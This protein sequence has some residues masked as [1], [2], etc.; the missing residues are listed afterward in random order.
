MGSQRSDASRR[1]RVRLRHSFVHR[2][3]EPS[4]RVAVALVLIV[5]S[6]LVLRLVYPLGIVWVDS[7]TYADAASSMSRWEPV[8][9]PHI[10]GD[11][12]YTQ[13]VRLSLIAPAALLY[14]VFGE[15]DSVSSLFP[16]LMSLAVVP[17]AF[18][19]TRRYFNTVAGLAA[20]GLVAIFP[21]SAII[22]TL[23]MPDGL[24]ASFLAI[25]TVCLLVALYEDRMS[26]RQLVALWFG[27]GAAFAFAF[28]AR[29]TAVCVLPGFALVGLLRWRRLRRETLAALA[30]GVGV[31][32]LFQLLL[33]GLGSQPLEDFRVLFEIGSRTR[34]QVGG[35]GFARFLLDDGKFWPFT[36]TTGVGLLTFALSVRPRAILRSPLTALA[37]IAL[38]EYIYFEFFMDLPGTATFR[39][40]QRYILPLAF[41]M[42]VFGGIGV[43][44]LIDW[45][46]KRSLRGAALVATAIAAALLFT[47]VR[48]LRDEYGYWV[49]ENHRVDAVQRQIVTFLATQ[50]AEPVY[51]SNDDFARPLS[52]R[53]GSAGTYYERTVSKHGLLRNRFDENGA[54]QVI[55]GAY[56]VVLPVEKWWALPTAPAEDWTKVWAGADGTDVYHVGSPPADSI[57]QHQT[58]A[59][60]LNVDGARLVGVGLTREWLLPGQH[61]GLELDFDAPVGANE[62]LEVA[63]NCGGELGRTLTLGL[64]AGATVFR[65]DVLLVP[66]LAAHPGLC[67]LVANANGWRDIGR[68]RLPFF[69]MVQAEDLAGTERT[70]GWESYAQPFF[71]RGGALLERQ[72]SLSLPIPIPEI[73]PGNYWVDLLVYD[74]G[75]GSGTISA[76]LNGKSASI[77]WGSSGRAR[78]ARVT[79]KVGHAQAGDQLSLTFDKGSQPAVLLD[80]V[81]LISQPPPTARLA[82]R[83]T[84]RP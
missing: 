51:A 63:L 7:F 38:L 24:V 66:P 12:Y 8:F 81:A 40:E 77:A 64:P 21:W 31:L 5:A 13:Y 25:A 35:F 53:M 65:H 23:F 72:N 83:A 50:P 48:G 28:Y 30:G 36:V 82:P 79:L 69:A 42:L 32:T 26:P 80:A 55:S 11:V 68:V 57:Q 43:G 2:L 41:P 59:P 70:A 44:T 3:S 34:P 61:S 47:T 22:S 10:V 84:E 54:S 1:S 17:L 15:S 37:V 67:E 75:S 60:A 46:R 20:A 4:S 73:A 62:S 33:I 16:L 19:F 76:T 74:Y 18:W 27:V 49:S 45:V 56:V 52:T 9:T 14:K 6:G 29:A 78:V 39:K 71:S 58:V